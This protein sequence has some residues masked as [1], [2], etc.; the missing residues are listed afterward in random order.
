MRAIQGQE[1]M[2][3]VMGSATGDSPFVSVR[4]NLPCIQ[5]RYI[6]SWRLRFTSRRRSTPSC[7]MVNKGW[8]SP[9]VAGSR[10]D[11]WIVLV[12]GS[13]A[14]LAFGLGLEN[15][16]VERPVD[17]R[18]GLPAGPGT[19]S[20]AS[21]YSSP[22]SP[23]SSPWS[24]SSSPSS[25]PL[26]S[27]LLVPLDSCAWTWTRFVFGVG[28]PVNSSASSSKTISDQKTILV[29]KKDAGRG[30]GGVMYIIV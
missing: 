3:S 9:S 6:L 19:G 21:V 18:G 20:C 30:K 23:G 14:T 16:L 12:D 8:A 24:L 1:R 7:S 4:R 15:G 13:S 11:G 29:M 26:F 17:E 22:V 25:L 2:P 5:T 10:N 27:R 28:E